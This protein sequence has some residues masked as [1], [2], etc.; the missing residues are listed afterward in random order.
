MTK[1]KVMVQCQNCLHYRETQVAVDEFVGSCLAL[2]EEQEPVGCPDQERVCE[3][4]VEDPK[5]IS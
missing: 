1:V 3:M 2:P 5:W 4:Y